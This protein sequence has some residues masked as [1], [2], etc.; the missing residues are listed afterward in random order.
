MNN[1]DSLK[2]A[3]RDAGY[4]I[5]VKGLSKSYQDVQALR[6]VD[7]SVRYGEVVGI[8]GPNGAGKTTLLEIL[9]GL[10]DYEVGDVSVLGV[11]VGH[12]PSALRGRISVTMQSNELPPAIKVS[13]LLALYK[14]IYAST[15]EVAELM[16]QVG[17]E[18]KADSRIGRLS[19]GQKQRLSLALALVADAKLMF[20]DEP[21]SELDPQG[22]R[23]VWQALDKR[24]RSAGCTVIITTHQMEEAA[25]LCDRVVILDHGKVLAFGTPQDLIQNFCPGVSLAF[26]CGQVDD[27]PALQRSYPQLESSAVADG[28]ALRL[29]CSDFSQAISF[30]ANIRDAIAS[31]LREMTVE[32]KTLEDV[33][34]HLTG[35]ILR[36]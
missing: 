7:L 21:T 6:G 12:A 19:G 5:Q 22:R 29:P 9:E 1:I 10:L 2:S 34:L 3:A 28:V 25:A 4:A 36:D 17:L 11:D 26:R 24:V 16:A 32:A 27:L 23:L 20:L 8:L 31:S 18:E 15:L 33:F 14:N 13:E 35:R 30:G